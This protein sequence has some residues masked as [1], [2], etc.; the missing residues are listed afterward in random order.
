M[1]ALKKVSCNIKICDPDTIFSNHTSDRKEDVGGKVQ[2]LL[3]IKH[4]FHWKV[5]STIHPI[6]PKIFLHTERK[7][8]KKDYYE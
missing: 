8:E 5:E 3:K 1:R 7:V 2:I 4:G 6:H